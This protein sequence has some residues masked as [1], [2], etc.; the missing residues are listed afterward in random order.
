VKIIDIPGDR[1]EAYFLDYSGM[2][3]NGSTLMISSQVGALP[4]VVVICES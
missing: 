2:D 1:D 3:M 4:V